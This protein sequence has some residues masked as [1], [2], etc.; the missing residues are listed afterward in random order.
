MNDMSDK[1]SGVRRRNNGV[2]Y[3]GRIASWWSKIDDLLWPEKKIRDRIRQKA[4][5][6][7]EAGVDTVVH[8]G[9]LYRFDFA[10]Y[11]ASLHG[12]LA[13]ISMELQKYGIRVIEA[14]S[15]NLVGRPNSEQEL[16]RLHS[17]QRH[18]V[19]LHMDSIAAKDASYAGYR[20]DTLREIDIGQADRHTVI[21]IRSRCSVTIIRIF[22][23]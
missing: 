22:W 7:S 9:F 4:Y 12:Y 1:G 10:P 20:F 5:D 14:F 2:F 11:F 23:I 3:P 21:Y 17:Y 13:D 8:I 6:L 19:N 18:C 15:C 16:K